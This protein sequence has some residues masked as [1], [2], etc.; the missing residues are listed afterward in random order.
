MTD[1]EDNLI[2]EKNFWDDD[3]LKKKD[4]LYNAGK[5]RQPQ[6]SNIKKPKCVIHSFILSF[7]S[8]FPQRPI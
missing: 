4:D 3:N 1:Y 8:N 2:K 5:L 7:L 6:K